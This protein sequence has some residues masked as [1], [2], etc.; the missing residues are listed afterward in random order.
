MLTVVERRGFLHLSTLNHLHGKVEFTCTFSPGQSA[1]WFGMLLGILS[2]LVCVNS[3]ECLE[4]AIVDPVS[5]LFVMP[6]APHN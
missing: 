2:S 6:P 5:S 3:R 1:S 4:T